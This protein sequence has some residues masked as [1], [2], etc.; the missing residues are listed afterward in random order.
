MANRAAAGGA[1][2]ISTVDLRAE[3][4]NRGLSA[5]DAA[6]EMGIDT[7]T[8]LR[9][10]SREITP[11]PRNAYKIASFYGYQVTDIWPVEETTAV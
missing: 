1:M 5:R 10:E 9:A 8:L 3:R 11:H 7:N 6:R 2:T 4:L